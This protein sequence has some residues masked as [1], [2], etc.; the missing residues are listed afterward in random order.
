ML[1]AR[2]SVQALTLSF[3]IFDICPWETHFNFLTILIFLV[4]DGDTNGIYST[5]LL[6]WQLNEI[7]LSSVIKL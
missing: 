6:L 3:D 7:I 1:Q 5:G 4:C 2:T